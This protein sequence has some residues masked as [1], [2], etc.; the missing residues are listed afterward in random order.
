MDVGESADGDV[1]G[2]DGVGVPSGGG[3]V[4]ALGVYDDE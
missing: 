4:C 2:G 1:G 3:V